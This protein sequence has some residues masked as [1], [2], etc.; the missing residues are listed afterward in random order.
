MNVILL[1]LISCLSISLKSTLCAQ[2]EVD[3]TRLEKW[4][5]H[6]KQLFQQ[7]P[8]QAIIEVNHIADSLITHDAHPIEKSWVLYMATVQYFRNYDNDNALLYAHKGLQHTPVNLELDRAD[9][10]NIIGSVHIYENR[11]D[12]AA[13][14][15]TKASK[16]LEEQDKKLRAGYVQN[17]I[18][19]IYI[20]NHDYGNA[21]GHLLRAEELMGTDSTFLT[22][23][24]G[25]ASYAFGQVD[26]F[27]QAAIYA[28]RA[29]DLGTK[30]N[31]PKGII[32]GY[33]AKSDIVHNRDRDTSQAII[34][35]EKA[36]LTAI[37]AKNAYLKSVAAANLFYL[38]R[39]KDLYKALQYGE[40]AYAYYEKEQPR[41]AHDISRDLSRAYEKAGDKTRAYEY[42]NTYTF[43]LDSLKKDEYTKTQLD[44]LNKYEAE[45]KLKVIAEQKEAIAIEHL[46]NTRLLFLALTSA[47]IALLV[48]GYYFYKKRLHKGQVAVM[49]K[50]HDMKVMQSILSGEHKERKRLSKEIHDGLANNIAATKMYMSA[51]PDGSDVRSVVMKQLDSLHQEARAAAH[52]LLPKSFIEQGFVAYLEEY[53]AEKSAIIPIH[54]A[55][56]DYRPKKSKSFEYWLLRT[57]QEAV[58]NALKYSKASRIDVKITDSGSRIILEVID[59]GIG[60]DTHTG[61]APL[62][63]LKDRVHELQGSIDVQSEEGQGTHIKISVDYA[64]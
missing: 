47:L 12:S 18:G 1:I 22:T 6:Y 41:F 13:Y 39:K 57:I 20:N 31:K 30:M 44:L 26:S 38:N 61:G 54:V 34:Y 60:F 45:K 19:M 25:N 11:N 51:H 8:E 23:V 17:N 48:L 42:L 43:F 15:L 24:V 35:S 50:D 55:V 63:Y 3:S 29:I 40:E 37:E 10:Y 53:A 33:L 9:F 58:G 2:T 16:I 4:K 14:Y 59:D 27:D 64:V 46:K 52:N 5:T 7:N 49:Q 28:D 21:L 56:D 32:Y 36:Y 62:A